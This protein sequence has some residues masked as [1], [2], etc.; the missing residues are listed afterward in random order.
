MRIQL[1]CRARE[2]LGGQ[3]PVALL[4]ADW[5]ERRRKELMEELGKL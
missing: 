2:K 3:D 4:C 1:S 5:R